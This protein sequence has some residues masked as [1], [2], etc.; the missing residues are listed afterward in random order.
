MPRTTDIIRDA[1]SLP[2]EGRAEIVESLLRSLNSPDS[3]ID[4]EWI[5]VAKRRLQE[6]RSGAVAAV[7]GDKVFSKVRRRF[8]G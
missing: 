1:E 4:Q 6:L 5:E 3:A 8:G 2:V 7:P